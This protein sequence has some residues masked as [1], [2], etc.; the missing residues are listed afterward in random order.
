MDILIDIFQCLLEMSFIDHK[1][2]NTKEKPIIRH[3]DRRMYTY[4]K[5]RVKGVKLGGSRD[6]N[7]NVIEF[8]VLLYQDCSSTNLL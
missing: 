6:S 1:K 5:D 3:T 7:S 2:M 8:I 4:W